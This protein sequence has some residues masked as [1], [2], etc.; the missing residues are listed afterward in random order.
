MKAHHRARRTHV[1]QLPVDK[2]LRVVETASHRERQSLCQAAYRGLVGEAHR[3]ETQSVAVIDPDT[4]RRGDQHVRCVVGAQQWFQN[5]RAGQLTL[6]FFYVV[7]HIAITKHSTGFGAYRGRDRGG[8]QRHVVRGKALT[9][10]I[11]Q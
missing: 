1:Q 11:D 8:A 4:I 6:Q 5:A 3:G 10:P 7:Q 9:Y 2:R